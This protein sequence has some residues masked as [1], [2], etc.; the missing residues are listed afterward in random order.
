VNITPEFV[1][2]EGVSL[3]KEKAQAKTRKRSSASKLKVVVPQYAVSEEIYFGM[4]RPDGSKVSAE[5][6]EMFEDQYVMPRFPKGFTVIQANGIWQ[7]A[8]NMSEKESTKVLRL[9][10][11]NT[12]RSERAVIEIIRAY[13]STFHQESVMRFKN[14]GTL[15]FQ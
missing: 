12:L 8:S 2:G 11:P 7:G 4:N 6:W 3:G 15:E 13:K 14:M 5:Q 9:M 10:H 1:E